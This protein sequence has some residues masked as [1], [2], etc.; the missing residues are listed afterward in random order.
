M[1]IEYGPTGYTQNYKR[2]VAAHDHNAGGQF[3]RDALAASLTSINANRP[4]AQRVP[5]NQ[6]QQLH[7]RTDEANDPGQNYR[8]I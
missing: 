8:A 7:L 4:E 2:Q 5:Q 6:L 3:V 1:K